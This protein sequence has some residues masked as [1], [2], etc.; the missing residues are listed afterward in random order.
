M[1]QVLLV[2]WLLLAATK[3]GI[4]DGPDMDATADPAGTTELVAAEG[5]INPPPK[6]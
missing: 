2:M 4:W 3:A 1:M 5:P 6:P